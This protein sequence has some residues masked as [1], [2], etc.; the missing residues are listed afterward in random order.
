MFSKE[1]KSDWARYG[2]GYTD[3]KPGA[4]FWVIHIILVVFVLSHLFVFS[5]R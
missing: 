1:P 4:S 5:W 3:K 2:F